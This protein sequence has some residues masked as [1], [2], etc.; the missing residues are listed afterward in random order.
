MESLC[1]TWGVSQYNR[2]SRSDVE[3][4]ASCAEKHDALD[5]SWACPPA[6]LVV[7]TED[8]A[9]SL[10]WDWWICRRMFSGASLFGEKCLQELSRM[11]H[12]TTDGGNWK[13]PA[14]LSACP[15][16][17]TPSNVLLLISLES[18]AFRPVELLKHSLRIFCKFSLLRNA[19]RHNRST[20]TCVRMGV[21]RLML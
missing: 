7:V 10:Y 12:V 16:L 2:T 1:V 19:C 17:S 11:S 14:T 20:K 18:F 6:V 4:Q 21:S 3:K 15:S 9:G 8:S 5:G 13:Q